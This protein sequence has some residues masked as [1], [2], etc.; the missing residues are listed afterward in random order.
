MGKTEIWKEIEGFEGLY[1]VSNCG[2]VKSLTHTTIDKIGRPHTYK[3]RILSQGKDKDGYC[4]ITLFRHGESVG[5]KVHRLVA[6]AFIP[7]PDNCDQINHIDEDKSNNHVENLEWC[8]NSYNIRYGSGIRRRS[9]KRRNSPQQSKPVQCFSQ[10]GEL[11]SIYPSVAEAA[12]VFCCNPERILRATT[13]ISRDA[14][15]CI[16]IYCGMSFDEWKKSP[17]S[18]VVYKRKKSVIATLPNDEEK[19]FKDMASA[20]RAFGFKKE[21]IIRCC[22]GALSDIN[23][24]KFR[25]AE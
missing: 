3:G 10:S 17:M 19:F 9:L 2:R 20:Q 14:L 23:G 12:R 7:K 13:G 25:Y 8:N 1:S 15:G 5:Y 4:F 21:N 18:S 22:R 6:F 11:I 16:W 24:I